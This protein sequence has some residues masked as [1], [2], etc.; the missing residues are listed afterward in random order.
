MLGK[1]STHWVT[2]RALFSDLTKSACA[3]GQLHNQP[4]PSSGRLNCAWRTAPS[5]LEFRTLCFWDRIL[6]CSYDWHAIYSHPFTLVPQV[7]ALL[8]SPIMDNST[9]TS[10]LGPS[11]WQP[12]ING[13]LSFVVAMLLSCVPVTCFQSPSITSVSGG[14]FHVLLFFMWLIAP[15]SSHLSSSPGS[16]SCLLLPMLVQ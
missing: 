2:P 4:G 8:V 5:I 9:K 16:L 12:G 15:T 10:S 13:S 7:P 1:C 3:Q 11:H 6:L 14:L